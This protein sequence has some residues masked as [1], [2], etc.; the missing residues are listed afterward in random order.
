[1]KNKIRV[2]ISDPLEAEGLAP[3]RTD[4]LFD[5]VEDKTCQN[6]ESFDA[7]LVRSQTKATK[8]LIAKAS[9]LKLIGRAGTGV[10]NID[11]TEATRRGILVI[12]APG[13]NAIA[14][15]EHAMALILAL[16]RKIVTSHT[17]VVSGGW[18]GP[19]LMGKEL[20]GKT[21]GLLGFGRI[22]REVAKRAK[23]FNM[24]VIAHDPYLAGPPAQGLDIVLMSLEELLSRADILSLHVPLTDGT[25]RLI[26]RQ[27]LSMMKP[28]ALLINTARGE[29]V[30]EEALAETLGSNRLAGA[31]L[32]VYA[33]EPPAGSPILA[34][35]DRLVLTPHT[36][37]STMETQKRVAEELAYNVVDY[38]TRGIVKG[39][40]NLPAGFEPE[41]LER[42][43]SHLSLTESLG[44]FLGQFMP[45]PWKSLSLAAG[46][47]YADKE[48][49]ALLNAGLRGLLY[50]ALGDKVNMVNADFYAKEH[51]VSAM[52]QEPQNGSQTA[53]KEI[54]LEIWSESGSRAAITGRVET[55]GALK[56]V[57]IGELF[58]D[59]IPS[60]TL[61]V[62]ANL[63]KPGMIGKVGTL[64][65]KE[66]IN[67]ADMRVGRKAKGGEA[68]MVLTI[69]AAISTE[70][71][72][73]LNRLPGITRAVCVNL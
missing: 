17:T 38:F 69:D 47:D 32:D 50:C 34:F 40:V 14:V 39:G 28:G 63:D 43:S 31:A 20:Y 52:A 45:G 6:L 44:R 13:A 24:K 70:T 10:D 57:K 5:L 22:G 37:A 61:L 42:L 58:V 15:S 41:I 59:V 62:I 66:K 46:K 3:F 23:A 9:R 29:I 56:I 25:R 2:L 7:W 35:S 27:T 71:M 65:G 36:A 48:R 19:G 12:N 4:G 30:D 54:T 55:N 64:L 60:G 33:K 72:D 18:R 68:I 8:D 73:K 16:T 21:L 67:I 11:V 49:S 51:G 1:M 26:N 53:L